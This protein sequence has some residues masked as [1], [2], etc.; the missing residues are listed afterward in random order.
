MSGTWRIATPKDG[1]ESPTVA[2]H[3]LDLACED[4]DGN[5]WM[6]AA[7]KWDGCVHL[8][9][10]DENPTDDTPLDPNDADYQHICDLDRLIADLQALA[11]K[12]RAHFGDDWND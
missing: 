10:Y 4:E 11:A 8:R 2:D 6:T 7:V 9:R 12:A 1:V 3:W 5:V